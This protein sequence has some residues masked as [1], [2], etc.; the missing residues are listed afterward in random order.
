MHPLSKL[1]CDEFNSNWN[2]WDLIASSNCCGCFFFAR[3]LTVHCTLE[4]VNY[5]QLISQC[6]KPHLLLAEHCT[7]ECVNCV[8]LIS[9]EELLNSINCHLFVWSGVWILNEVISH[10]PPEQIIVW[11]IQFQLKQMRFDCVL[12]LLQLFLFSS[13]TCWAL[14]IGICKLCSINLTRRIVEFY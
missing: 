7:L 12:Q 8:Q 3:L 4:Y 9:Q 14:H 10:A 11:W 13:V 1:L 5:F 2:E 6:T